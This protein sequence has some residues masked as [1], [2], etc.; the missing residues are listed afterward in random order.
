MLFGIFSTTIGLEP[1]GLSRRSRGAR[2]LISEF[3]C[4]LQQSHAW[5]AY[6]SD[7]F[8]FEL[9]LVIPWYPWGVGSGTPQDTRVRRCLSICRFSTVLVSMCLT[10]CPPTRVPGPSVFA[11]NLR[12]SSCVPWIISTFLM[13]PNTMEMLC[14]LLSVHGKFKLCL[15]ELS[16]FFL[17]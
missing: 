13:I 3:Y 5:Q 8:D 16:E 15:L 12:T 2:V 9:K 1:V 7:S 11:C 10:P 4:V 14:K 17:F 6:D